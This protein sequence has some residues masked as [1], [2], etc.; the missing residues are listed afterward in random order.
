MIWATHAYDDVSDGQ[1]LVKTAALR[2]S[3]REQGCVVG[4]PEHACRWVWR[5]LRAGESNGDSSAVTSW[6]LPTVR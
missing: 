3:P 4:D 1:G 5:G 6:R 2:W